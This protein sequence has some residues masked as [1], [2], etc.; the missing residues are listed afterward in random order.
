MSKKLLFQGKGGFRTW[1]NLALV[2][3]SSISLHLFLCM[4]V[5]LAKRSVV[6]QMTQ[7][8]GGDVSPNRG[9]TDDN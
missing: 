8:T 7:N 6:W 1:Q 4:Q 3:L 2:F 9:K 5:K